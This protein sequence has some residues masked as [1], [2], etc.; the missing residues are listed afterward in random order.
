MSLL[1]RPEI[2]QRVE[3]SGL[4]HLILVAGSTHHRPGQPFGG[5]LPPAL[6]IGGLRTTRSTRLTASIVELASATGATLEARAEDTQGVGAGAVIFPFAWGWV[7]A[8]ESSACK[9]LGGEV[10]GAIRGRS[11]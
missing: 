9:A 10:V 1:S 3:D 6:A 5:A 11:P 2:K 7:H 8:T 4:T